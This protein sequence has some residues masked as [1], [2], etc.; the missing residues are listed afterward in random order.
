[1]PL[2]PVGIVGLLI[3]N[4]IATGMLGSEVPKIA[5]GIA[6]GLVKWVPSIVVQTTDTGSL[7]V[8]S[9]GPIPLVVPQPV[10]YAN[11]MA[12]DAAF[13]FFGPMSPLFTLGVANGLAATFAQALIKTTHPGVGVGNGIAT[14][15]APPA[16]P[17]MIVGFAEATLVGDG[18]TSLVVPVQIVGS[19]S[20]SGG[21]GTGFGQII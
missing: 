9:G 1:M 17:Q 10:L 21:S 19:A 2:T 14:F 7:G 11:L 4:M 3:P 6:N 8:G 5:A 12:G 20:P 15:R 16:I 13:S 18:P